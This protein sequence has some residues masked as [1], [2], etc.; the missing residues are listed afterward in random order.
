[1]SSYV[2]SSWSGRNPDSNTVKTSPTS[3]IGTTLNNTVGGALGYATEFLKTVLEN[4]VISPLNSLVALTFFSATI[5]YFS[6]RSLQQAAVCFT[7]F[8]V[9]STYYK[10]QKFR[11]FI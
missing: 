4:G 3:S 1:M 2:S 9:L 6:I 7:F 10:L 5:G 11:F 8:Y